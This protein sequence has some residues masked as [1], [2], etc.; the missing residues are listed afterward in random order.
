MT[1]HRPAPTD[2]QPLQ[3]LV[4]CPRGEHL[5]AVRDLARHWERSTQIHW[6]TDPAE[7]LERIRRSPPALAILDARLDRASGH[8]L[9]RELALT[10]ADL[11][12]LSFDTPGASAARNRSS[13]WHWAELPRA[14]A[15]WWQRHLPATAPLN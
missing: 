10:A 12:V 1:F 9:S 6:T 14:I 13:T 4:V 5:D 8:R 15:W 11:D 3:V 7:A 2:A